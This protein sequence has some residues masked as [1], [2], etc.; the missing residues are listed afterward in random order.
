M[1]KDTKD[2]RKT[3]NIGIHG[4]PKDRLDCLLWKV[5]VLK[6]GIFGGRHNYCP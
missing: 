5:I 3:S 1:K 2:G 4:R 6:R